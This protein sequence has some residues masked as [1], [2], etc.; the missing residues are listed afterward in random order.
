MG[1]AKFKAAP[2]VGVLGGI[3]LAFV[4][5][6]LPILQIRLASA[7]RFRA[8]FEW[9]AARRTF[10]R[11]PLACAI[12]FVLSIL[13][14]LPLYLLKIEVVPN[15]AR[16]LPALIFILFMF[17]A[18]LMMGW[19]IGRSNRRAEPRHWFFRWLGRIPLLPAAGI[20][21]LFVFFSQYTSWNGVLSLYEQHEFLLPVPFLGS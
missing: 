14:A 15:E 10:V 18:R 20:Y 5:L 7:N 6:Y 21:V 12:V 9:R 8:I 19:A 11:A 1:H 4:V 17:P 16:W 3:S 2:L 13:F